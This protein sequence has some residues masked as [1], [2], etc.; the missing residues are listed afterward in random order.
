[1]VCIVRA[2]LVLVLGSV[3]GLSAGCGSADGVVA[4]KERAERV[5][6]NSLT[7]LADLLRIRQED[8]GKAPQKAADLAKYEKAFP[9]GY[10]KLKSGEVVLL[11]D[12]PI[13]EGVADKIL[14]YEKQTPESGGFVLM[15]DAKTI[16]KL[17][18]EEFK[19]APKASGSDSRAA[20]PAK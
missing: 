17:T 9:L 13:E 3:M 4:P 2:G 10:Y 12:A 8:A 15:Q 1:M 20:P 14:A 18:A 16:K 11:F 7:Q 6:E 5:Q 19:S